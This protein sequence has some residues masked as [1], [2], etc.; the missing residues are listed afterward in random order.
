MSHGRDFI[1][2][3]EE[4]FLAFATVF[5]AAT[6]THA[7]TL[8]IPP[9]LVTAITAKLATYTA[10]QTVCEQPNA[11]KVDRETRKL[12]R[13][14][15]TVDIRKVKNAYIDADPLGAVTDDIR[16]DFGLEP[17]DGIRTD[18]STP[19]EVVPFEL[20][21][22]EYLQIVVTHPAKPEEYNGAVAHY[23]VGG[24]VP[25]T[26]ALLTTS[27]LLTRPREIITFDESQRGQPLHISL[28]WQNRKGD[29]GPWAPIQTKVIS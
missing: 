2:A 10:A 19:R 20:E 13:A 18:V 26:H 12:A 27:K 24:E 22:G 9:V 21:S 16:M 17:K 4:K 29:L 8:G 28:R 23:T 14:A 11:G 25:A 6:N 1:P 5:V 7:A 15:L 3:Q